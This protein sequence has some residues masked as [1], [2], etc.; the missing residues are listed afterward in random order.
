MSLDQSATHPIAMS[1]APTGLGDVVQISILFYAVSSLPNELSFVT[2]CALLAV[3]FVRRGVHLT[4]LALMLPIIFITVLAYCVELTRHT[5]DTV[6]LAKGVYYLLRFPVFFI[7]G[8]YL[9]QSTS[10]RGFETAV[11]IV[12]SL[13]GLEYIAKYL[14][15]PIVFHASREYIR[16]EIGTGSILTWLALGI[17]ALRLARG[18]KSS[19]YRKLILAGIIAVTTTSMILST[20]RTAFVFTALTAVSA[21][22]V[23]R[24]RL[25]GLFTLSVIVLSYW[26]F[27]YTPFIDIVFGLHGSALQIGLFSEIS[28][29]EF[30]GMSFFN[31]HWRGY[32]TAQAFRYVFEDAHQTAAVMLG[33]GLS[34]QVDLGLVQTLGGSTLREIPIFHNAYS[35][36]FVRGGI[37]GVCAFVAAILILAV[38]VKRL[39]VTKTNL[40]VISLACLLMALLSVPTTASILNP[41]KIGPVLALVFGF[42]AQRVTMLATSPMSK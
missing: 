37:L 31:E 28:A 14:S 15:D 42:A 6:A 5:A 35:F 30:N 38:Q 23:N 27:A 19:R 24:T 4:P 1:R 34:S 33:T 21:L 22:M 17:A 29:P 11:I 18:P 39:S 16:N 12:G 3:F 7:L 32:E 8:S 13:L 9:A 26:F 40:A 41:G 2:A 10:D 20:S 25:T 36:A